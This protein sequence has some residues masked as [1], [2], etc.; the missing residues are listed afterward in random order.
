MSTETHDVTKGTGRVI[1]RFGAELLVRCD[2]KS[3]IRCAPKRKLENIACGDWVD[4]Q[5][6]PTGIARVDKI[7]KRKNAIT[8]L[9][10]RGKPRTIAANVDQLLIVSAWLPEPFWD[11]VDRYIIA[12]EQLGAEATIVINKQDLA[13]QYAKQEGW[14]AL[15]DYEKIG[16]KV[17]HVNTKDSTGIDALKETMSGKTNILLGRSG[18][19]K[20]SIANKIMP[21][22]AILTAEI[23]ESGEGRH[24]TTTADLYDLADDGYLIDSPGVRDYMPDNLDPIKLANGYIEFQPYL[25][26]CRFSNCTHNHEPQCSVRQ[27]VE[28][29]EISTS[30]YERY[31]DALNNL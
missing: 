21:E 16:Y 26:S 5:S 7:H 20:S 2:D 1:T 28:E 15:A 29:G 8:R 13:E 24:T 6:N 17:L 18:V 4:W 31:L 3:T 22:A 19:G 14:R 25:N 10:Y 30:R 11:L 23:S 9:T 27:A 12:A